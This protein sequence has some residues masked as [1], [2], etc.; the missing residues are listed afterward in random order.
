MGG[1][2]KNLEGENE[3]NEEVNFLERKANPEERDDAINSPKKKSDYFVNIKGGRNS[4]RT[5]SSGESHKK[6]KVYSFVHRGRPERAKEAP[7]L[8][9]LVQILNEF[10]TSERT[11][12]LRPEK[13]VGK[14]KGEKEGTPG[15]KQKVE[16]RKEDK[17]ANLVSGGGG[18]K[19]HMRTTCRGGFPREKKSTTHGNKTK[20]TKTG[21]RGGWGGITVTKPAEGFN[22]LPRAKVITWAKDR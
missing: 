19:F 4:N 14:K 22:L 9:E 18:G 2:L 16:E 12:M 20:H 1:A 11:K 21:G 8:V 13:K 5:G 7:K 10:M 3:K 15:S 17:H 6:T